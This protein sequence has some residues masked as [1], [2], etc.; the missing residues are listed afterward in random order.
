[1]YLVKCALRRET[2]R[3]RPL[4]GSAEKGSNSNFLRMLSRDDS[5]IVKET[6][7][8]CKHSSAEEN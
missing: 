7:T 2:G 8:V 5:V 1:M 4:M 3:K 6:M